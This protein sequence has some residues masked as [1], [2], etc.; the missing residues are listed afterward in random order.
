MISSIYSLN[1]PTPM[2]VLNLA[3][4]GRAG[5]GPWHPF[6]A[7][8]FLAMTFTQAVLSSSGLHRAA[9]HGLVV[10]FDLGY[11]A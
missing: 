6:I 5:S 2:A 10:R 7:P 1:T 9:L 11:L 8:P 3:C 4:G